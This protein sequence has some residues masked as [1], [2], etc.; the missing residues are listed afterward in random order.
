MGMRQGGHASIKRGQGIEFS[1]YRQ[2]QL[3]DNPRYIDWGLYGRSDKLYVKRFS[4][5]QDLSVLIILDT[6]AS[7][8]TPI[9]NR[10]TARTMT[11][12]RLTLTA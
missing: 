6:S 12:A 11:T 3:G 9:S 2:Y 1:D 10:S 7:M 5:E 8:V 4:E